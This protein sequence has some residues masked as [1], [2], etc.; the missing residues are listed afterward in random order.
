MTICN[1]AKEFKLFWETK[2]KKLWKCN[3]KVKIVMK[4]IYCVVQGDF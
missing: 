3:V 1:K 2:Q 4:D